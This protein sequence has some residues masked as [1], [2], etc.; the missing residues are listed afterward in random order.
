MAKPLIPNFSLS[1]LV[2]LM[3]D[4]TKIKTAKHFYLPL[5]R[6]AGVCN[7]LTLSNI[8]SFV[9]PS[10]DPTMIH[11]PQLGKFQNCNYQRN[12]RAL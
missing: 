2:Y 11:I 8:N 1:T 7:R 10:R 5:S 12:F 9:I 6:S 3:R 4:I